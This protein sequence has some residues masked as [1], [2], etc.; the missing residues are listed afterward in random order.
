MYQL[1]VCRVNQMI[2]GKM[3]ESIC[4][5]LDGELVAI[6][7]FRA[8][9]ELFNEEDRWFLSKFADKAE[10]VTDDEVIDAI[11]E[12]LDISPYDMERP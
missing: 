4:H 7:H 9:D 10:V 3:V 8:D 5:Y 2:D 1:K 6:E 11:A 12:L